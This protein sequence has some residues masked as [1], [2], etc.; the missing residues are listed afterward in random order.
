MP[1]LPSLPEP[2]P[3]ESEVVEVQL[4]LSRAQAE[5]LEAA[6]HARNMTA[7]QILRR[8]ITDLFVEPP[9]RR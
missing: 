8:I 3:F 5:A 6:A 1:P 2:A 9:T 4:L 7:G